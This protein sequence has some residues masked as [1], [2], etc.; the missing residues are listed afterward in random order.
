MSVIPK[1]KVGDEVKHADIINTFKC[2]NMG[3]MLPSNTTKTLV[4]I[5]DYTKGLYQDKWI[6]GVL[7][8]TGT[9]A[10]GDQA[11]DGNPGYKN[12]IL[13][14]SRTN[15]MEVHLFEVLEAAVYIYCGVVS[16]VEE[17]YQ[18]VQ[19]DKYGADRLVWM[20]PVAPVNG[21]SFKT[22]EKYTEDT[23]KDDEGE[24]LI[25][26][27]PEVV[28]EDCIKRFKKKLPDL[29]KREKELEV[30]RAD[31]VEYYNMNQLIKMRKEEYVIG[32][33]DKNTFCYRLENELK[34]L[35]DIHGATSTKFGLYYGKS[36]ED[37]EEK[38]RPTKHKFGEDPDEALE[39]IK[40][41][42]VHLRM[43]GEQKDYAAIRKCTL[44][45]L[46]RGKILSVFYP[47]DFL[48]IFA[49]T[50]LDYFLLKLGIS[51]SAQDDILS[52]Q[53]KLMTWKKSRSEMKEWNNH[54][55]SIFLYDCF[56]RPL[57]D[58]K[59]SKSLQDE[60]DQGYPKDYAA[61]LGITI[62][63]W[64]TMLKNPDI[65]YEEDIAFMKRIY[66]ADNHATSCY[67]LGIEDG[68]SPTS[69]ISP[70][71]QLAKRIS[72]EMGLA[73]VLGENGKQVWWRIPFWGRYREDSRFEW[74]LRPKLAKA[75]AAVFPELENEENTYFEEIV[76][77]NLVADL[78]QASL[79]NA[80]DDFE[81]KGEPKKKQAP[82]FTNGH[83][84]YPRDKQTA[85]NALAH[86]HYECECTIGEEHPT[87]VRKKSDKNYTEP[88]HLVPMSESDKFDVSLDV[89]EN[90]VSLCSNCHN[91]IHYGRD[92]KEM[93]M[94]LYNVRKE[95]LASVGIH[96]T[97]PE[98]LEMYNIKG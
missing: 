83:R 32:L 31:F 26:G 68:V 19:K 28:L 65:F 87:F 95:A 56:G 8:Y 25:T 45:S 94:Q 22:P 90:I 49:E 76:D 91:K 48:C 15:G 41:Q 30:L 50:H 6:D 35:G 54:I 2:G 78:K 80:A 39:K 96:V 16:I 62:G 74:K 51:V 36:G 79:G 24:K 97:L 77:D 47:E 72:K 34:E 67:D 73:P 11:L 46:F 55:F 23:G 75:M 20:F 66:A 37:V 53:D 44:A 5:S 81:Y 27:K 21:I 92:A 59:E 38:Y 29:L 86:A 64:K 12:G 43:A 89:E 93:I 84:T 3:G 71:V 13:Y 17:P 14:N 60:R 61:K 88:H 58:E 18:E 4:I 57:E 9:G 40:E 33:G 69:Y 82:L 52:K 1:F 10:V 98:L 70:V 85:I 42:I 63:Q 7:H